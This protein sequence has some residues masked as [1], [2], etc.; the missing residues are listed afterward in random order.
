MQVNVASGPFSSITI[1]RKAA[2]DH[3]MFEGNRW[4]GGSVLAFS[5]LMHK[6]DYQLIYV[7][8]TVTNAIFVKSSEINNIDLASALWQRKQFEGLRADAWHP[9][10]PKNRPFTHICEYQ[11]CDSS[12]D[13]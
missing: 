6:F 12:D 1:P 5:K 3:G 13:W 10:D 2:E 7:E 8:S 9:A 4:F 11:P